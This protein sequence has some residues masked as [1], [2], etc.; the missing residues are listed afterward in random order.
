[1]KS[2]ARFV[3]YTRVE[4]P[5]S[6]LSLLNDYV[7][8]GEDLSRSTDSGIVLPNRKNTNIGVVLKVGS[9]VEGISEGDRILF[10]EWQGGKWAFPDS[11]KEDGQ[12]KCLIMN[13]EYVHCV[14]Q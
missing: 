10:E 5:F 2:D 12:L 8:V 7:A 9:M 4:L 3:G 13:S 14:L 6:E 11:N 1:M